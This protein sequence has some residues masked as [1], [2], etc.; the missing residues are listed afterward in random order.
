MSCQKLASCSAVQVMSRKPLPRLVAVAQQAQKQP[1][2]RVRRPLAVA[3]QLLERRV[4]GDALVLHER[5]D[6]VLE[7]LDRQ[8]ELLD[9]LPAAPRNTGCRGLPVE[10]CVKLLPPP[11]QQPQRQLRVAGLVGQVVADAAV[12]VD[13]VDVLAQAPGQEQIEPTG[14]FS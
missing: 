9:R 4:A 2:D 3:Q 6:Q 1:P 12:G 11:L 14:K 13:V 8:V 10:A 7:R 5:A